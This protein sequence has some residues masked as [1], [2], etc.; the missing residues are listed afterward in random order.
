MAK[1]TADSV[2]LKAAFKYGSFL[3]VLPPYDFS[4]KVVVSSV[5]KKVYCFIGLILITVEY[6]FSIIGR[7]DHHYKYM[8]APNVLLDFA[9]YSL[10]LLWN[11][12]VL[13]NATFKC[14]AWEDFLRLLLSVDVK[15]TKKQRLLHVGLFVL[16]HIYYLSVL[17]FDFY[18]LLYSLE[19]HISQYYFFQIVQEYFCLLTIFSIGII[20]TMLRSRFEKLN[21]FLTAATSTSVAKRQIQAATK[22]FINGCDMMTLFNRILDWQFLLS[23]TY[24]VVCILDNF[25]KALMYARSESDKSVL[26]M[27]FAVCICIASV[28]MVNNCESRVSIKYIK[29]TAFR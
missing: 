4:K 29:N 20:N 27:Q 9:T 10:L 13:C 17:L 22:T 5:L 28:A 23:I 11:A 19:W 8:N 12:V 2:V 14:K 3:M 7:I 1:A 26:Y 21:K 18:F 6:T 16:L 24:A 15:V 25:E